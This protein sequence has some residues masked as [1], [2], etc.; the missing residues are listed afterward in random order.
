MNK[1]EA[2]EYFRG[3]RVVVV[4]VRDIYGYRKGIVVAL[5]P[6][7]IGWSMVSKRD[8]DYQNVNPMQTP[9]VQRIMARKVPISPLMTKG[10]IAEAIR[11]NNE[12]D[13][14]VLNDIGFQK[15]MK[16][17]NWINVPVFNRASGL[18]RA[19]NRAAR[20]KFS[21]NTDE[22]GIVSFEANDPKFPKDEDLN[23]AVLR[24]IDKASRA[25]VK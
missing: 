8:F 12:I 7:Q 4:Y 18:L 25:F 21:I 13:S 23:D 5:S 6:T 17:D 16:N 11:A 20:S 3:N 19:I 22:K 2:S 1:I 14:A 10:E 24:V 15:V 9:Y